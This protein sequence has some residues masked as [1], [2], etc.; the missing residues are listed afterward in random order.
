VTHEHGTSEAELRL[1]LSGTFS[2]SP[3]R[4]C[5]EVFADEL[6]SYANRFDETHEIEELLMLEQ[7]AFAR[8]RAE[9]ISRG[10]G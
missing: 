6:V 4:R 9:T 1:A 10:V 2:T 7:R 3:C 5:C 8:V